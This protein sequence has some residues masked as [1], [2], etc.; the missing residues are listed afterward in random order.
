MMRMGSPSAMDE[1][2]PFRQD[3]D[4][5]GTGFLFFETT[6]TSCLAADAFERL[7]G[8]WERRS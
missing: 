3:G 7:A 8:G 2:L 1:L 5:G 6:E 4:N